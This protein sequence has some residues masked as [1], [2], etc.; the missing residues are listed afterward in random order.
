MLNRFLLSKVYS[1][2]VCGFCPFLIW[3]NVTMLNVL[4]PVLSSFLLGYVIYFNCAK[5]DQHQRNIM[6][7]AGGNHRIY[8]T[9]FLVR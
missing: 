3:G 1:S 6:N 4:E 8:D 2:R 9:H 7:W 5:N